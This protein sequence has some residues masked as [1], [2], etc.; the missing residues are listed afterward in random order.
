MTDTVAPA[1]E[2]KVPGFFTVKLGVSDFEAS[3]RFYGAVFGMELG[4]EWDLVKSERALNWPEP[5]HGPNIIMYSHNRLHLQGIP[6]D[7]STMD[8]VN[9]DIMTGKSAF[10]TGS[11]WL[12]LQVDD[13]DKASRALESFGRPSEVQDVGHVGFRFRLIM[14]TDP[15][16]NVLEIVQPY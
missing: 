12:V 3:A 1:P 8:P 2:L 10:R 4:P 13:V 5:G 15:D 7:G 9:R 16:G 11:S 6:L 14:T